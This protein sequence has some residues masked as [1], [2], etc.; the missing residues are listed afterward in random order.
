[1]AARASLVSTAKIPNAKEA[2]I[3]EVPKKKKPDVE[4]KMLNTRVP[5]DLIKKLK[6]YC[7]E[8]E[9]TV[10]EFITQTLEEKL[11]G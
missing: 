1:M 5:K 4:M 2:F 3:K 6:V 9:T 7:A 11:N 8:H 10:Q